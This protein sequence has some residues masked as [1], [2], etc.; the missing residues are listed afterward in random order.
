V[1]TNSTQNYCGM[2]ALDSCSAAVT[3]V[4]WDPGKKI[5][6][7]AFAAFPPESQPRLKAI[8]FGINY[9]PAK[10]Y[11]L[12]HGTCADFEI[13]DT[14]WPGPGTGTGQTW[15]TTTPASRLVE[16]YWFAGYAY[17]ESDPDTTSFALIPHPLHQGVFVDDAV[18]AVE[19]TIAA[20]GRLGFGAPGSAPCP[21]P[22]LGGDSLGPA[23]GGPPQFE[24]LERSQDI[25]LPREGAGLAPG[26]IWAEGHEITLTAD[27]IRTGSAFD[28][29][30]E[31]RHSAEAD[32]LLLAGYVYD[33]R[34]NGAHPSPRNYEET[35]AIVR[36]VL[37]RGAWLLF[38]HSGQIR[39]SIPSPAASCLDSAIRDIRAG[40]DL[41]AVIRD[42][43]RGC[44]L[45]FNRWFLRDV[46][47][48]SSGKDG[49][50]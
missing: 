8:T 46:A 39:E 5:V 33:I 20:Y 17:S 16:V 1:F 9:D 10:F 26:R 3:S 37:A 13:A 4:D 19:D 41:D 38:T 25:A 32:T 44:S 28:A 18:P 34:R 30:W 31:L 2:S 7:Y 36:D 6:F 35:R 22:A 43:D 42:S 27:Q 47:R 29:L 48:V 40:K 23:S 15:T 11:L 24:E 14:G 45:E 12:G 21:S 49:R 50:R